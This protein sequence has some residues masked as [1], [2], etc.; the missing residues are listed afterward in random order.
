MENSEVEPENTQ[1]TS[2]I[3]VGVWLSVGF[4][5]FES[6]METIL[7][8]GASFNSQLIPM[9]GHELWM[10][11]LTC[12]LF[13]GFGFYAQKVHTRIHSAEKMNIDAAWLLKNALNNTI[14]G[15]YSYCVYCK[16][17]RDQDDIW[18]TPERF[19]EARTEAKLS[20]G[21]C[22]ECHRLHA[23]EEGESS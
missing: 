3:V 18:H 12:L 4:W 8:E 2:F 23:H 19:I 21:L 15:N 7:V 10:R 13:V 6:F 5:L 11:T 16:K 9:N 22:S 17:I 1:S 20:A 14:R